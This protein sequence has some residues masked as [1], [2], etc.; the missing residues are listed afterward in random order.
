M[1]PIDKAL[2]KLS[3]IETLNRN[4][5]LLAR[6]DAKAKL[7]T[8][9]AFLIAILSSPIASPTR[10]LLFFLYPIVA[11][12]ITYVSYGKILKYSLA[13]LPLVAAVA[14]FNPFINKEIAFFIGP[15]PISYGWAS[16]FTITLRGLLA[17]QAVLILIFSTGF[18]S[19]CRALQQ[20]KVP[21]FLASLLLMIYRYL[22]VL[23]QEASAMDRARRSRGFGKKH[24][25]L[26]MWATFIS[27]LLLRSIDRAERIN[28]AMQARGW[29]GNIHT[30][31]S[32]SPSWTVAD[33]IYLIVW[34]CFFIALRL[35]KM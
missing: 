29:N 14:I 34:V 26:K 20:L 15:V 3:E 23:L 24:Y 25:T 7:L 10:L 1:T 16:F 30:F 31:H 19:I 32:K 33:F 2:Y 4:D 9:I 17:L 27:Q 5:C 8:T 35:I 11:C 6:I 21:S 12:S 18:N 13:V 22:T 28:F